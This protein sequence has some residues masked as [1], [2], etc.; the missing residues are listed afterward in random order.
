MFGR[1]NEQKRAGVSSPQHYLNPFFEKASGLPKPFGII[2]RL[3][4]EG[5]NA[6]ADEA[7][8][9]PLFVASHTTVLCKIRKNMPAIREES[10]FSHLTFLCVCGII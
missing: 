2:S 9:P 4:K 3:S 1:G 7:N 8:E 5:E 6:E 10:L